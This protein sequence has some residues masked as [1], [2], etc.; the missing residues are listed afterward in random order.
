MWTLGR[1]IGAGFA[2]SFVLLAL[3]GVVAYRT[4]NALTATSYKVAH[5]HEVLEHF[6]D[7]VG[8]LKDAETGQRGYVI[9]GDETFLE[10]YRT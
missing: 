5:S 2:L 9:T 6:A 4:V 8:L 10:P 3:I 1:K 7:L